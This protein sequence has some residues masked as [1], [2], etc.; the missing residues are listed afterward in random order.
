MVEKAEALDSPGRA[1]AGG[2][3]STLSF[4]AITIHS[5]TYIA[6]LSLALYYSVLLDSSRLTVIFIY[7]KSAGA[8]EVHYSTKIPSVRPQVV[9]AGVQKFGCGIY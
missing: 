6:V 4:Q 2:I 7:R 3:G 5:I 1:K 8:I 9:A